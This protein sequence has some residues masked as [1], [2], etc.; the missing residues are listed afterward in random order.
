MI[1]IKSSIA[2]I[3]FLALSVPVAALAQDTDAQQM[4]AIEAPMP[5]DPEAVRSVHA[6]GLCAARDASSQS[7]LVLRSFPN[8][9][10]SDRALFWTAT[11]SNSCVKFGESLQYTPRSLRGPIAEY[12]LKRDFELGSWTPKGRKLNLYSTPDNGK[13]VR[14]PADV[15][16]NIVLVELGSCVAGANPTGVAA[17]FAAPVT[18]AEEKAAVDALSSTLANCLPPSVELKISKAQLRS[19]LAEGAYRTAAAAAKGA[20]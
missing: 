12:Y 14:L 13:L 4:T 19:Y 10:A 15:R 16:A 8:S 2:L 7:K 3:S 9:G 20:N 5:K 18:S 17:L 1:R 6:F 11:G